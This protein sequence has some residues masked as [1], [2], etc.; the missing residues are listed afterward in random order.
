MSVELGS[1]EIW[2]RFAAA[3]LATW[4][5]AHLLAYEDGPGDVFLRLRGW[6]GHGI[7]GKLMDCFYCLSI[8]IA[9]PLAPVVTSKLPDA[10]L[11]WVALSGAACLL[12]RGTAAAIQVE[13]S[14][15][16][17]EEPVKPRDVAE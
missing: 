13:P 8:W 6:L 11:V 4:R 15:S 10:V 1:G 16:G 12:E 7:L 2:A 5:I 3:S 9:L 14:G 17:Q